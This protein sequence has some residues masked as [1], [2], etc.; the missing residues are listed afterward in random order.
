MN[1]QNKKSLLTDKNCETYLENIYI[2]YFIK[3]K[4]KAGKSQKA[5]TD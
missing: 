2:D 3:L 5:H 1:F 4:G